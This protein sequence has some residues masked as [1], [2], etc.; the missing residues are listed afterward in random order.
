MVKSRHST[1]FQLTISLF[2]PLLVLPI[3]VKIL[4]IGV[5]LEPLSW[6][7]KKVSWSEGPGP[8]S[9][10]ELELGG[11][12]IEIAMLKKREVTTMLV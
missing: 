2:L 8:E 4:V 9:C 6:G 3:P 5:R 11:R 7:E 1:K 12:P 10:L